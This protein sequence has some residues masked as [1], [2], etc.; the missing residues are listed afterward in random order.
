ML[1][2]Q[3]LDTI[4]L[5]LCVLTQWGG[6]APFLAPEGSIDVGTSA[7]LVSFSP[8][9]AHGAPVPVI[10]CGGVSSFSEVKHLRTANVNWACRVVQSCE[11]AE[12]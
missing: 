2:Y 4:Q 7:T 6:K 10:S 1:V 12:S 3:Q 9:R 11:H 8:Q 5:S